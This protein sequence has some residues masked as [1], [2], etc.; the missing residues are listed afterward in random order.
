MSGA[1]DTVA[2]HAHRASRPGSS[3][4]RSATWPRAWPTGSCCSPAGGSPSGATSGEQ[5]R[6]QAEVVEQAARAEELVAHPLLRRARPSA[7]RA[8]GPRAARAPRRRR[9]RGPRG[10]SSSTP[11]SP[12][13]IWSWMPPTAVATTGP[14][15]PHRLGDGQPEAL[16]DALLHD[17]VGG[18]LERVDDHRVLL[19][20]VHRQADEVDAA[21][22][23]AGSPSRSRFASVE[24]LGALGVVGDG[25]DR[26]PGVDQVRARLVARR[27]R[28]SRGSRRRGSFRRSQRETCR[29]IAS[30]GVRRASSNSSRLALDARLA[31]VARA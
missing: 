30:S 8:R 31:A 4:A 16:G 11:V 14:R 10:S 9:R 2:L 27:A 24:H 20:V 12:S 23:L 22:G 28:R 26:R 7:R 3:A 1:D 17:D 13:M 5:L 6:D 15:L 21:R 19:G 18:A 29:T 25:L